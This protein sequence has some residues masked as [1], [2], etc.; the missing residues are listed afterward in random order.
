MDAKF[1]VEPVQVGQV[2][3]RAEGEPESHVMSLGSHGGFPIWKSFG[4]WTKSDS[5]ARLVR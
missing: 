2:S 4:G 5:A 3:L 1:A